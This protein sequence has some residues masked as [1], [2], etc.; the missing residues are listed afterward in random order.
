MVSMMISLVHRLLYFEIHDSYSLFPFAPNQNRARHTYEHACR[1]LHVCT[2]RDTRRPKSMRV[3]FPFFCYFQT[4]KP[5]MFVPVVQV[6]NVFHFC[7][8]YV[9]ILQ[10]RTLIFKECSVII[11]YLNSL[12]CKKLVF[13][14]PKVA[15]HSLFEHRKR[16]S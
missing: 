4:Y 8:P 1:L 16:Q 12:E 6:Q 2:S 11:V 13:V 15:V 3:L 7:K 10:Y 9:L 14:F 5:I